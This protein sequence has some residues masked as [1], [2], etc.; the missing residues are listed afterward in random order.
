MSLKVFHQINVFK[1][2]H[3]GS[4]FWDFWRV[5]VSFWSWS[6]HSNPQMTATGNKMKTNYPNAA[7]KHKIRHYYI[8]SDKNAPCNG[9]WRNLYLLTAQ[10]ATTSHYTIQW[11][12]SRPAALINSATVAGIHWCIHPR[13]LG[14]C[15]RSPH[16]S[17][18]SKTP[19]PVQPGTQ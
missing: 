13:S 6:I 15:I 19:Q 9:V 2:G 1:M 10:V 12:A 17:W 18:T 4:K 8:K 3:S 7:P 16:L 11:N 14:V 5:H